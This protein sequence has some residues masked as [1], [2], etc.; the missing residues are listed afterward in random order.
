MH[1][2]VNL[3]VRNFVG[4]PSIENESCVHVLAEIVLIAHKLEI[5]ELEELIIGGDDRY[6]GDKA[7]PKS[8]HVFQDSCLM[9]I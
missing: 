2:S 3:C 8:E 7:A 9:Q 4:L 6:F 1:V 5:A